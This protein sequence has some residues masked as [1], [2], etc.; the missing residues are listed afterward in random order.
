MKRTNLVL[1]ENILEQTLR[2]SQK[3]TYSEAVMT[4]MKE[5]IRSNEFSKIFDFQGTGIWSGNLSEMRQDKKINK[6][7][8]KKRK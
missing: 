1:D 2:L 8:T 3:K 5:F 6:T 7:K 4:A